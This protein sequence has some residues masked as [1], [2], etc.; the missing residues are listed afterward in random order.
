MALYKHADNAVIF[1]Q[2]KRHEKHKERIL[3]KKILKKKS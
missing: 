1:I 3:K 2:P